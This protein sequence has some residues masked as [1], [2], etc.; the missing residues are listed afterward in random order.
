MK[1]K[2][3]R[4][5]PHA[6]WFDSEY[7][8]LRR[9]RRKAEKKFRRTRRVED[10][11][12]FT[13][14]RKK[15]TELAF[16]KKHRYFSSKIKDCSSTKELFSCVNQLLDNSKSEV[17]PSYQSPKELADQFNGFFKRKIHDI[18]KNFPQ[19]ESTSRGVEFSGETLDIFRPATLEEIQSIISNFGLK[20][21]PEDPIPSKLL[22]IITDILMP[23]W[24]ELVNLS[25][26]QGSMEC[27][28]S[29]V[30]LPLLKGLDSLLDSEIFKNYRP[31]SN[32]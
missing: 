25:L 16:S 18:R 1:T 27:L 30:V 14:L 9:K 6:P 7:K 23:V 10:K 26:E 13:D 28:K 31:V 5:A 3:V 15:T 12:I 20:C 2:T 21:S 32:L 4:I 29:A 22:V 17:L 19:N 24:L 11:T 8:H